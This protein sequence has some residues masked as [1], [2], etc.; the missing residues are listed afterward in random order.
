MSVRFTSGGVG[1]FGFDEA[2]ATLDAADAMVGRFGDA[3]KPQRVEMPKPIVARLTADLGDQMFEPATIPGLPEPRTYTVWEWQQIEIQKPAQKY[4]VAA[5]QA[6]KTSMKFGEVP[7]GRAIQLGGFAKVGD[8]V[9]LFKM[10]SGNMN[11]WFAFSAPLAL[12]ISSMLLITATEASN[13]DPAVN[14]TWT[15]YVKPVRFTRT[16]AIEDVLSLPEG[17]AR[18]LY[19]YG[20]DWGHG[21]RLEWPDVQTSR[22]RVDGAVR[23]IVHGILC[24]T[25]SGG[26]PA[27]WAFEAN[28]PLK[29]QCITNPF[30]LQSQQAVELLEKGLA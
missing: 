2:N 6:G 24:Q 25:P 5:S 27:I 11:P 8:E 30:G 29:P 12:G 20:E 22:M 21:Q 3:G 10:L 1:R 16:F 14:K 7:K 15:Y 19:E 28:V 17:I 18:N 9:V 4:K 26:L 23:G 13:P